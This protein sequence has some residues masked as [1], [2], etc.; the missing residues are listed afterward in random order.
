MNIN[1]V[2]CLELKW[3]MKI[4]KFGVFHVVFII[5]S[6]KLFSSSDILM[7]NNE[8]KGMLNENDETHTH[9]VYREII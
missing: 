6:H 8:N 5:L 4:N 9:T 2:N 1:Q 7:I 3:Q